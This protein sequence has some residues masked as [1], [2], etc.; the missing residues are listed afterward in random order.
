M[1]LP[2]RVPLRVPPRATATRPRATRPAPRGRA[3]LAAAV[4]LLALAACRDGQGGDDPAAGPASA[5]AST[6]A[7]APGTP[8]PDYDATS[9]V[10]D[11]AAGFPADLLPV[12]PGAEVL[13]SSA[14]PSDDGALVLITLNLRSPEAVD[15]LSAYYA[16]VL[17]DAG[18]AL[19]PSSVPSALTSLSTF[20]RESGDTPES[21]AVGVF[22]D[23]T[24]R[25]VTVS[26]QV[27]AG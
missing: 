5:P 10:G 23:E 19:S 13:A 26:G 6:D 27:A 22:D 7:A 25:L 16:Q 17:D 8:L 2:P 21:V 9:A 4:V 3:V 24:E 18:F 12:P 1:P 15:A 20:V 11:L 14:R